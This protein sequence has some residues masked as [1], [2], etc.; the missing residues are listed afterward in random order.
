M[1]VLIVLLLTAAAVAFVGYPLVTGHGSRPVLLTVEPEAVFIAGVAY[2][3][4]EEWAV[5]WALDKAEDGVPERA[6]GPT[7]E[8]VDAE[9]ERRVA[10]VRAQRRKQQALG[11]AK[12][13]VCPECGKP[14]QAG[15]RFC[16][17]CGAPHPNVCPQCGERHRPGDLFCVRCGSALPGGQE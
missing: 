17:R 11:Q 12:R 4:E 14:F 1:S 16:A 15:D 8:E 6:T 13:T 7:L 9:I 5:D 3:S 2:A 10:A